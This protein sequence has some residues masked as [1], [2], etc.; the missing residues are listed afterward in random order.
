MEGDGSREAAGI[1]RE[2]EKLSFSE[3]QVIAGFVEF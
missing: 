1:S 2:G 3:Q